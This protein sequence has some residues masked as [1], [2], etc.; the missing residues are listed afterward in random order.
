[1]ETG[2]SGHFETFHKGLFDAFC[3]LLSP[4]E[5]VFLGLED[6]G[7]QN[8]W[9]KQS[10]PR[11]L[12]STIPWAPLKVLRLL[13][14]SWPSDGRVVIMYVYEG[15][16]ANLFLF[17]SAARRYKHICLH[18]NFFG[19]F[20]HEK[21]FES[22][23][24]LMIFKA[25]FNL[26]S[27]NLE[28]KLI[29]TADTKRFAEFMS[30]KLR[31]TILEFPTYSVITPSANMHSR[32]ERLLLNFRG[33]ESEKLFMKTLDAFPKL[34]DI[35]I[36]LHGI[37]QVDIKKYFSRFKNIRL[38][39]DQIP[40][41]LYKQQFALYRR[42]AFLYDPYF[43]SRQS[44]GRLADAVISGCEI[45]VPKG[46]SLEDSLMEFGKGSSFDFQSVESLGSALLT[47]SKIDNQ[48]KNLPTS[49]RAASLILKRVDPQLLGSEMKP[50]GFVSKSSQIILDEFIRSVLWFLRIIFGVRKI[51]K[52]SKTKSKT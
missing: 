21:L 50:V 18:F 34:Q 1:L 3:E 13:G 12:T 4:G 11:S 7:S 9:Y 40:E 6:S 47:E 43:F 22:R 29:L 8:T 2:A 20:K 32:R 27:R 51:L 45:V 19:A 5:S 15:S 30:T 33:D 46:T 41:D 37:H 31:R 44:S 14:E 24:R 28:S 42:V 10:L 49:K 16:L 17:G 39:P 38:L 48:L 23:I 52:V 26:A 25:L 36:D 35:Q